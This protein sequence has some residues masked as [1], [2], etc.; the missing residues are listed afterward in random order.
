MAGRSSGR[1][2]DSG[3]ISRVPREPVTP[4]LHGMIRMISGHWR[5]PG[6]EI[7]PPQDSTGYFVRD[8]GSTGLGRRLDEIVCMG[9]DHRNAPWD[10]VQP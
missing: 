3:I 10:G 1:L 7:Q 2:F 9:P 5:T 6:D 8:L 4:D